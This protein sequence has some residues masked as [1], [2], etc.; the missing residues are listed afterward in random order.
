MEEQLRRGYN[1]NEINNKNKNRLYTLRLYCSLP[2][3]HEDMATSKLAIQ[4]T[5]KNPV[6]KITE[7]EERAEVITGG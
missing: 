5:G 1:N 6:R 7:N 4:T 2:Q 3:D